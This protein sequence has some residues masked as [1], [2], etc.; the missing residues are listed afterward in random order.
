MSSA[1]DA[2]LLLRLAERHLGSLRG[3]LDP[4]TLAEEDWGFLAQ[5]PG[6]AAQGFAGASLPGATPQPF[7][8]TSAPGAWPAMTLSPLRCR[9]NAGCCWSSLRLSMG[10]CCSV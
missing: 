9:L 1:E 3:T 2:L 10:R 4:G 7:A 8:A 6:E 5:D